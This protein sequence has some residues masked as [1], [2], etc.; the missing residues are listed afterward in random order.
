MKLPWEVHP[1]LQRD[2]LL[3]V[4]QLIRAIRHEALETHDVTKGETNWS[5]GCR[6]LER[7]NHGLLQ[8]RS[9]ERQW[10]DV[11]EAK[12]H[13]VFSI[14]GVPFRVYRGV[15]RPTKLSSLRR[16][17]PEVHAQQL[18]FSFHNEASD[19]VNWVWRIA[20]ETDEMG[21]VI[22]MT[23]FQALCLE[24]ESTE[25]TIDRV[26]NQWEIPLDEQLPSQTNLTTIRRDPVEQP[27]PVVRRK[28]RKGK[29]SGT[30]GEGT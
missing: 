1:E 2:R 17:Y 14:G 21:R 6:V 8:S 20:V 27:P 12:R 26:R 30:D 23:V 11:L 7:T 13:F 15:A 4:G 24:V 22:R 5:L 16:N 10:F 29:K 3:F 25:E 19:D 28:P 9:D 18:A